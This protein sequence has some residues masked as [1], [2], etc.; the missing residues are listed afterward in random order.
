ML[1][2]YAHCVSLHG[3]PQEQRDVQA[4]EKLGLAVLNPNAPSFDKLYQE[5]GMDAFKDVV[6]QCD[7]VAFRALPDGGIPA[8]VLKEIYWAQEMG[9]LVFELPTAITRRGL[10]VEATREFLKECGKR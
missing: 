10:S 5:Q 7:C 9:K 6:G 3:T 2:Y 8:G 4:L 1:C